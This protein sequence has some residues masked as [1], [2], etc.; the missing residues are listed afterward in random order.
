MQ[1]HSKKTVFVL[2]LFSFSTAALAQKNEASISIGAMPGSSQLEMFVGVTCP[3]NVPNCAGPISSSFGAAFAL[4]GDFTRQILNLHLASIGAEFPI[5]SVP[6][7]NASATLPGSPT[8][9]TSFSSLFFTPSARLKI[10]PPGPVAPF[11]SIGGGL[12]HY[13][14]GQATNRGAL[15]IGGGADFKT[16][17]PHLA[18]RVEVRDF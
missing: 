6:S 15:Q 13:S 4:E 16:P 10:L 18:L 9:T 3:I 7:R 14:A 12:A 2:L 5:L 17:L 11:F 1:V 8:T